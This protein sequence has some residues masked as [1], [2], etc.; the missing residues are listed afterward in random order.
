MPIG[1]NN[2]NNNFM[3]DL[4][5]GY[6]RGDIKYTVCPGRPEKMYCI[7]NKDDSFVAQRQNNISG[8]CFSSFC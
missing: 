4:S 2:L 8:F 3:I 6:I 5:C 7:E 1:Q